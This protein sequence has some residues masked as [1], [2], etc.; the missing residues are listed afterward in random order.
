MLNVGRAASRLDVTA[1]ASASGSAATTVFGKKKRNESRKARRW[2][3]AV[4]EHH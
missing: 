2:E 4:G 1:E 3:A